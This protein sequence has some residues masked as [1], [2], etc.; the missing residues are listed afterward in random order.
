MNMSDDERRAIISADADK[1]TIA[2]ERD[3]NADL[4][5]LFMD[6]E[7][8]FPLGF[9]MSLTADNRRRFDAITLPIEEEGLHSNNSFGMVCV[10]AQRRLEAKYRPSPWQTPRR[11]TGWRLRF[12]LWFYSNNWFATFLRNQWYW[13]TSTEDVLTRGSLL[14]MFMLG[15]IVLVAVLMF[16]VRDAYI[17][18]NQLRTDYS[19]LQRDYTTLKEAYLSLQ[20]QM[21]VNVPELDPLPSA[22]S[23]SVFP[24][25][26][27][28]TTAI[29]GCVDDPPPVQ[30]VV[31]GLKYEGATRAAYAEVFMEYEYMD[32]VDELP[33]VLSV[34]NY[35]TQNTDSIMN[36]SWRAYF[37]PRYLTSQQAARATMAQFCADVDAIV[38][39]GMQEGR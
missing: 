16:S 36:M 28:Y 5:E 32:T 18:Y 2:L 26:D 6:H 27:T 17:N 13:L 4:R 38:G 12:K 19:V 24:T 34:E 39:R 22:Q 29:E 37:D 1:L 7:D 3:E 25:P 23:L 21:G 20:S 8:G 11:L 15:G 10:L 35:R 14:T 30:W 33:Y 31:V 9:A